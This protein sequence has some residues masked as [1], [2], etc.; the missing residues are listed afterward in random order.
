MGITC[1]AWSII[2]VGM[3]CMARWL[4]VCLIMT[5]SSS[6]LYA[7]RKEATRN[8]VPL[9]SP[10]PM[11]LSLHAPTDS[12]QASQFPYAHQHVSLRQWSSFP[13]NPHTCIR[14]SSAPKPPSDTLWQPQVPSPIRRRTTLYHQDS[15]VVARC[16][17]CP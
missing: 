12:P 16:H 9:H 8:S 5:C 7:R 17:H 15:S 3:L 4:W 13:P 10:S 6:N 11:A 2:G 14:K 1:I